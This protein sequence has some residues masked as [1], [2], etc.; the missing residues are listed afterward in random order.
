MVLTLPLVVLDTRFA[1]GEGFFAHCAAWADRSA[2]AGHQRHYV[3][4]LSRSEAA[5][6]PAA[7]CAAALGDDPKVQA[8]CAAL[9]PQLA[10]FTEFAAPQ[11]PGPA[12]AEC[13]RIHLAERDVVLTLWVGPPEQALPQL[14]LQADHVEARSS[15]WTWDAFVFKQLARCCQRGAR[16]YLPPPLLADPAQLPALRGAGFV[17]RDSAAHRVFDPPWTLRDAR[18]QTPVRPSAGRAPVCAVIGAGLSGASVAYALA[19]S[20]WT[21]DVYEQGAQVAAGAS[22]LPV[23]LMVPHYSR[24]DSPRSRLARAGIRLT[25]AHARQLLQNGHDWACSGALEYPLRAAGDAGTDSDAEPGTE[26]DARTHRAMPPPSPG[27]SWTRA[28]APLI[29][30]A[31]NALWHANAG[32]VKPAALVQAWLQHPSITVHPLSPVHQLQR[33][34][35]HGPEPA[36]RLCDA[37]GD[38]LGQADTVVF[39]QARATAPCIL[40]W[41]ERAPDEC[42]VAGTAREQLRALHAVHGC[43]SMGDARGLAAGSYPPY[44]VHGNGHFV[45]GVPY[46]DTPHWFVGATY[47]NDILRA[48]DSRAAHQANWDRLHSLLPDV[49]AQLAAPF[50]HGAVGAWVGTRCVSHDRLPLVGPLEDG[51]RPSLWLATAMGSR[52]LSYAALAAELLAAQINHTPWPLPLRLGQQISSLRPLRKRALKTVPA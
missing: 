46:G 5:L 10:E 39:A 6:L 1:T 9:L 36:W 22:G 26:P 27:N 47:E 4:L 42:P 30:A 20:G 18:Y 51:D 29:D 14:V 52:G 13:I 17:Q 7:L 38:T 25:L 48:L 41:A 2:A 28:A 23:G 40:D 35:A 24:D 33:H 31:G 19:R 8:L 34:P 3:G 43:V 49:A 16:V 44:P 21:V 45:A 12:P 15:A 32:W 37:A 11:A 50:Q